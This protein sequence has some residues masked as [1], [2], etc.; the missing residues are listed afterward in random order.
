MT[1]AIREQTRERSQRGYNRIS[2][3]YRTLEQLVFGTQLQ[4]ARVALID[5]LPSWDRM[6]ILGDGDG[7]LLEAILKHRSSRTDTPCHVKTP[8]L[9]TSVDQ[10]ERML[11][12]QRQRIEALNLADHVQWIHADALAFLP[13]R[14]A[15]DVIVMPF[16]L[17]CFDATE[18]ERALP[19][20]IDGLK[21]DGTLYYVDFVIPADGWK[22]RRAQILSAA[23]HFFFRITT[24]LKNRKL[25]DMV[26]NLQRNGL[27]QVASTLHSHDMIATSLFQLRK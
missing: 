27:Q 24:G 2:F 7:R 5:A 9:V 21:R 18:L 25:I 26:P 8:C 13:D 16:F 23:M 22:R 17:D 20:W 10:S 6:L 3:C 4:Q 14:H 12:R 1:N 19:Q 11:M 15:F